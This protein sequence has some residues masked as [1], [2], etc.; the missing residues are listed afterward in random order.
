[1]DVS[2]LY[3]KNLNEVERACNFVGGV[4]MISFKRCFGQWNRGIFGWPIR[5][6]GER[7][8]LNTNPSLLLV[9]KGSAEGEK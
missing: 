1:M 8:A 4:R 7:G 5:A 2:R 3:N 6:L 9:V